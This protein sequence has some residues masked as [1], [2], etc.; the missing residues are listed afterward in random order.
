[1]PQ[2]RQVLCERLQRA[3]IDL[4]RGDRAGIEG[5]HS[6]LLLADVFQRR[7]PAC[8]ECLRH[9]TLLRI[10][11]FVAAGGELRVIARL[12]EFEVERLP[13]LTMPLAGP[14]RRFDRGVN[15]LWRDG[16]QQLLGHRVID[17]LPR[18]G[19]TG[20]TARL[21]MAPQTAKVRRRAVT[22]AV[23][24]LERVTRRGPVPRAG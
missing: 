5:R 23:A 6:G 21:V 16:Q 3:G 15:R 17:G 14:L 18:A 13:L 1:M 8:F 2:R 22:A 19:H 20:R 7:V 11:V 12:F 24:D 10:D 9:Q 4:L